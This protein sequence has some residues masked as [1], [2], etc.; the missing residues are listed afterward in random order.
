MVSNNE[1]QNIN[2]SCEGALIDWER[3]LFL[4]LQSQQIQHIILSN[5]DDI[6]EEEEEQQVDQQ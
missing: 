1:Q 3:I 2:K 5:I 6:E 4:S